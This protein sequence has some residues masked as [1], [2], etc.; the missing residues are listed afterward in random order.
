MLVLLRLSGWCNVMFLGW[1]IKCNVYGLVVLIFCTSS[2]AC[3]S[4][5]SFLLELSFDSFGLL[6]LMAIVLDLF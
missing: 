6:I 2:Y 3:F 1:L 5:S 4:L